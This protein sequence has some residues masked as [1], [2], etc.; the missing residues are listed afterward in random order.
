MDVGKGNFFTPLFE[1]LNE[2][3]HHLAV[4]TY[5]HS[6]NFTIIS[7]SI[8]KNTKYKCNSGSAVNLNSLKF[9]CGVSV[10]N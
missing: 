8:K 10:R 1:C 2:P 9:I 7:Y 3:N 6:E 4:Y 5:N